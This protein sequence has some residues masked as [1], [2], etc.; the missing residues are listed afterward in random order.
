M[1]HRLLL[2]AILIA[3]SLGTSAVAETLALE[4]ADAQ[5]M[6]DDGDGRIFV[7]LTRRSA[8]ALA[9][10][11]RAHIRRPIAVLVDGRVKST[12]FIQE[13]LV[14][15]ALSVGGLADR[16]EALAVSKRLRS[17]RSVLTVAPAESTGRQERAP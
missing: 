12:P 10:F 15:G 13:P 5:A 14:T 7:R 11:T 17:G 9:G 16:E 2:A 6:I 8:T 4:V 1:H 3:G